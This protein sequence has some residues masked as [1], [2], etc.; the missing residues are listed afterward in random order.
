MR[1]AIKWIWLVVLEQVENA[2][3]MANY[4]YTKHAIFKAIQS[5]RF[6]ETN[7][8]TGLGITKPRC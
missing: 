8:T 1:L 4:K 3:W 5:E 7:E 2:Q 6:A